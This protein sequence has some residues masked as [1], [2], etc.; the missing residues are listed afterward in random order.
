MKNKSLSLSL[1]SSSII[2]FLLPSL[3]ISGS[4]FAATAHIS[5]S[6]QIEIPLAISGTNANVATDTVTVATTCETGYTVSI[7]SSVAD[8]K[9]YKDGDNTSPHYISPSAGTFNSPA[10]I[11]GNNLGTW[12][13]SLTSTSADG[14]FIG[15]TNSFVDITTKSSSS[16]ASGDNIKIYY[17]ASVPSTI[18]PGEYKLADDGSA[19]AT[20]I[21]RLTTPPSC[22]VP[23]CPSNSI[24][25]TP[26]VADVTDTMGDQSASSNSEIILWANNFIR[27]GYG[28]AGWQTEDGLTA[29]GPNETITTGDLSEKGLNLLAKWVKSEGDLQNWTGCSAMSIG[30]VTALTDTRDNNTYAIA[31]LKDGN[32]WMIENL[33]LDDSATL[34]A[35]NT[36][37]PAISKLS[38][39]STY[40]CESLDATCINQSMLKTSNTTNPVATMTSS[41]ANIVGYGNYYNW[42]SATAGNG[43]YDTTAETN[44]AGSICPIGWHLPTGGDIASSESWQLSRAIIGSD[45]NYLHTDGLLYYRNVNSTEGADASKAMRSW[46]SN[47][48]LSGLGGTMN[49]GSLGYYWP[50]TAS[51]SGFRAHDL[52]L[53]SVIVGPGNVS[54][55]KTEGLSVRCLANN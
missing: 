45:P 27:P 8:T 24:C 25:Y 15:L 52:F 10:S 11:T 38:A 22:V 54:S 33:R 32:C 37:N 16:S 53:S 51:S 47:F 29:Y 3:A 7:A 21:Y 12:G 13:Y 40:W 30:D 19:E 41:N 23:D 35:E 44:V 49:L 39:H 28:F 4:A 17:G 26:D 31:K 5:T 6:G 36:D 20:I 50:S 42:Y 2:S 34:T 48:V 1:F 18:E 46:P 9:L 43:T 14:T 55:N